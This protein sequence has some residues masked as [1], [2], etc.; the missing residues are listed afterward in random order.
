MRYGKIQQ[1]H[2]NLQAIHLHC[3]RIK[4]GSAS[5]RIVL[6]T[7]PHCRKLDHRCDGFQIVPSGGEGGGRRAKRGGAVVQYREEIVDWCLGGGGR[8][9]EKKRQW[10]QKLN[11]LYNKGLGPADLIHSLITQQF[12]RSYI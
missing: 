9:R 3:E 7:H 4:R 12:P 2:V 11:T 1:N 5:Q 8:K 10:R 6:G